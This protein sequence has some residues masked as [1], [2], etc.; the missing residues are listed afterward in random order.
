MLYKI[1]ALKY[2]EKFTEKHLCCAGVS[3]LTGL[4][5]VEKETPAQ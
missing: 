4:N 2:L 3:F 1:S 5:F